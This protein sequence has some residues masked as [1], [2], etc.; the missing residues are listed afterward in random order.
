[1]KL[2]LSKIWSTSINHSFIILW[3]HQWRS[4]KRQISFGLNPCKTLEVLSIGKIISTSHQ[5]RWARL[6]SHQL[7]V[8]PIPLTRN[9]SCR[10]LSS[11][12]RGMETIPTSSPSE[13]YRSRRSVVMRSGKRRMCCGR[14]TR[15]WR[16]TASSN[17]HGKIVPLLEM[18][19]DSRN[20]NQRES[21]L[22]SIFQ[23]VR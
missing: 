8:A 13:T 12:G 21:L 11:H 18:K 16:G 4:S 5:A 22:Q 19:I 1:M 9:M 3:K 6:V 7:V 23:N 15:A 20:A 14:N 2:L 17:L 10:S